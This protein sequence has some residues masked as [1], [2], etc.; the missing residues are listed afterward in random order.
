MGSRLT[1]KVKTGGHN[2]LLR[3]SEFGEATV[4]SHVGCWVRE[5]SDEEAYMALALCNAQGELTALERGRHALGSVK[6]REDLD[7]KAYAKAAGREKQYSVVLDE[8]CAARV[9]SDCNVTVD[10]SKHY[11]K[12]VE[13]HGAVEWAWPALVEAM[14]GE[15]TRGFCVKLG[16]VLVGEGREWLITER[17]VE[18]RRIWSDEPA[19]TG[20]EMRSRIERWCGPE[21]VS[22]RRRCILAGRERSCGCRDGVGRTMR[23]VRWI[24]SVLI[25]A[26]IAGMTRVERRG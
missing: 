18:Q 4:G 13:I 2:F 8:V 25:A 12:L 10:L 1:E 7:V 22:T 5:M 19:M 20:R 26:R 16:F 3:W 24:R 6:R 21:W 11:Q 14:L 15:Q 9:A 17:G 23:L